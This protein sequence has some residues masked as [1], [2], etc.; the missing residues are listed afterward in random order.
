M[1]LLLIS[2]GGFVVL[3]YT[4]LGYKIK[5]NGLS[6]GAASYAGVNE[7]LTT[8]LSMGFG[9]ILAGFAG[10]FYYVFNRHSYD[11]LKTIEP[12][13]IGF[14]TIAISLLGNNSPV[15]IVFTSFFYA[16]LQNSSSTIAQLYSGSG[17]SYAGINILVGFIIYAAALSNIFS[18]FRPIYLLSK[19]IGI[20]KQKAYRNYVNNVYKPRKKQIKEE[21][22]VA[23][24]H[25]KALYKRNS[26]EYERIKSEIKKIEK[27]ALIKIKVQT[28]KNFGLNI[29]K[30]NPKG[31]TLDQVN[32][33]IQILK[34]RILRL[35]DKLCIYGYKQAAIN[36]AERDYQIKL[37]KYSYNAN[38]LSKAEDQK[39]IDEINSNFNP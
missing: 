10:F 1:L 19:L 7:K 5:M 22:A 15:G 11:T 16:V 2:A 27:E 30:I 17:I 4:S 25:A 18:Q 39:F 37:I 12:I 3:K 35:Q 13:N 21:T 26:F 36:K 9:G 14:D 6:L 29:N 34:D 8:I 24:K 31:Y 33:N 23:L 32:N 20:N 28:N 38:D